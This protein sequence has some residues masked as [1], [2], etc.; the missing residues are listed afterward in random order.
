M[1][2]APF[3]IIG[4]WDLLNNAV[5]IRTIKIHFWRN[6]KWLQKTLTNRCGL[7]YL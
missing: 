4:L 5:I 7:V 6:R 1:Y 2:L 3:L